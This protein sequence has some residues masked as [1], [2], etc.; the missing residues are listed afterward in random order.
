MFDLFDHPEPHHS[1]SDKE[2]NEFYQSNKI[3]FGKQAKEVLDLLLNGVILTQRGAME[4]YN[5]YSL[6]TRISE[7]NKHLLQFNIQIIK[8]WTQPNEQNKCVRTYYLTPSQISEY[9]NRLPV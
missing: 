4:D 7:C 2:V 5:I 8:G 6:S 3:R 9:H 1:E